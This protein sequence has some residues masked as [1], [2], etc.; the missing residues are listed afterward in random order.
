MWNVRERELVAQ[1]VAAKTL[2][3][4]LH[5]RPLAC[6]PEPK[7]ALLGQLGPDHKNFAEYAAEAA[8][9][10]PPREHGG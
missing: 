9:T 4:H 5:A 1:G 2:C 7:N 6:L 8:R 10:I 3:S